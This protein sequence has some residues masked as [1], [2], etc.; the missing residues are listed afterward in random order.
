MNS[1]GGSLPSG[2]SSISAGS[3]G[4]DSGPEEKSKSAGFR[5]VVKDG[6]RKGD[7]GVPAGGLLNKNG[8][9]IGSLSTGRTVFCGDS[10]SA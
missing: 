6:A 2:V 5:G 8:W 7:A 3:T 10:S 9:E 4:D 1:I